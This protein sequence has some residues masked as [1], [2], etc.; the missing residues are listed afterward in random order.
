M[1]APS[2][3]S[4][5]R[6]YK[7][8]GAQAA[9][10]REPLERIG[11]WLDHARDVLAFAGRRARAVRL[12]Q[13]AGS[14][15]FTTV[16][17]LVPLL[18]VAL[19]VFSAFPLFAEYR[20]AL[21]RTLVTSLLPEQISNVILRYL[22]EFSAQAT[23]VTAFGLVFLVAAALLMILTVDRVL[24]DIWQVRQRR[25][26]AQRVLIYWALLT[27]GPLIFGGSLALTSYLATLSGQVVQKLP[28]IVHQVL[29]FVPF[30][31]GGFAF[32]AM[33]V[34][35]PNR[36]VQWR[37]ALS[38][39]FIASALSEGAK[40]VFAMY[41]ARGTYQSIYGAFAALPVFLLW[42][43]ISWWVTLFGA[44]IA[45]TL[46]MLRQTRFADESRAGNRFVT[47]VALLAALY[48]ALRAGRNGGRMSTKAL[49]MHVR[50]Y[51]EHVERL[52]LDL[53]ALDYVSQLNGRH[54]GEW[55][56]TASPAQAN[57]VPLFKRHA[58]DPSNTLI[59]RD[60]EGLAN[61]MT[62]GLAADWIGRPLAELFAGR[63]A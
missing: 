3:T 5:E 21:E 60:V 49:A 7:R 10:F 32:A 50:T 38:G 53:E 40:L 15:T 1:A 34:F 39:G 14:L 9:R 55:L 30:A 2:V 42:V 51:P 63:E 43:Y 8:F 24:N 48:H 36:S 59:T 20:S 41:I 35:V 37:D 25:P 27:I 13:V 45:A 57:L 46:P 54:S 28:R 56:L 61:W 47:A 16:L 22:Q 44:A 26:L 33:Y 11:P 31:I 12:S 23:R 52:L 6:W 19:A 17:S 29:D 18:A 62:V 58:V 4:S